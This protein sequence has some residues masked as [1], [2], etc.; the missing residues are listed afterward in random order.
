MSIQ[1]I[2]WLSLVIWLPIIGGAITMFLGDKNIAKVRLFALVA[3]IITLLCSL[4]LY[5]AFDSSTGSMQFTEL[6]SWI[7]AFNI[8]YAL[9]VDGLSMPFILLTSFMTV[10]VVI[11]G[12]DVITYKRHHYYAAFLIMAGLMNGVFAAVDS[13]LFYIFFEAML[14]PM[15]LIIGIWGGPQRV[16]A[17]LKFFLYTFLGSI[18]LLVAIIYLHLQSTSDTFNIIE[19]SNIELSLSAQKWIFLAFLAGFAVKVPMVPVH[20]WLPSA[21]VE[22]PTGGSVIL[23][24]ITLKIGGYGFVRFM[25]PIVP[26]G[27]AYYSGLVI[28]LSIIAIIYISIVALIQKDMKKMIAYSSIAHMGFVTLGFT[29]PMAFNNGDVVASQMAI[30]GGMMQMISHGFVSAAMFLSIGVMYDRIH[31]RQIADYGGV[32]NAMPIFGAFFIFFAMANSGLPGT[33]GFIGEF[34]VLM[35]SFHYGIY[36]TIAVASSLILSAAYNLWLTKRVILGDIVHE[37]VREMKDINNREYL[38]L[39][40]LAIFIVLIGVWPAPLA[41][42]MQASIDHL[43]QYIP[44]VSTSGQF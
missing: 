29:L 27:M 26:E 36:I 42:V 8:N 10:I 25:M 22:A 2:P 32:I 24:A 30:Q 11:A 3:S 31:S 14:I 37:H 38:L 9:G 33:S 1:N 44:A 18:F 17:A 16:T 28:A 12:W 5:G 7:P 43:L 19:F 21:H 41:N 6:A 20:T 35:A 40:V 15:F 39:A 34:W 13:V 4:P 23:A